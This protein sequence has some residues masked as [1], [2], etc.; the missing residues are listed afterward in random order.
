M[1]LK[2]LISGTR[3]SATAGEMRHD[4]K[5]IKRFLVVGGLTAGFYYCALLIGVELVGWSVIATSSLAYVVSLVI[6]YLMHYR[7]SFESD[8]PHRTAVFLYLLMNLVGFAV[9][10]VVMHSVQGE[11][12]IR[13]LVMQTLAIVA[14]VVWNYVVSNRCIY[15]TGKTL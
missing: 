11:S 14:I 4:R 12:T 9:N 2:G 13:Y 5:K 3:R 8:R 15:C 7:W 6:N 1:C 10:W